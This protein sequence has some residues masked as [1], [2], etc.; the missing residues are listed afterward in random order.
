MQKNS[1]TSLATLSDLESTVF[2]LHLLLCTSRKNLDA[3]WNPKVV[4]W[5]NR[6]DGLSFSAA[7]VFSTCRAPFFFFSS[8]NS[9]NRF[10]PNENFQFSFF[11]PRLLPIER[12]W[13]ASIFINIVSSS[14]RLV[15]RSSSSGFQSAAH[16]KI[17]F[18]YRSASMEFCLMLVRSLN[19]LH[20]TVIEGK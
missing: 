8:S 16:L 10:D 9:S 18:P 4:K 13:N 12:P 20:A 7:C 14:N 5:D 11:W 17:I 6:S 15:R 1:C 3:L 19:Q 2:L